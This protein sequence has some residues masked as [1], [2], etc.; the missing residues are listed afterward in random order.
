MFRFWLTIM[1]VSSNA[2]V[3]RDVGPS[4]FASIKNVDVFTCE[5]KFGS[6]VLFYKLL[7]DST[8]IITSISGTATR[9]YS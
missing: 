7:C 2:F 5:A 8:C 1:L 9:V 3:E 6:G 4:P